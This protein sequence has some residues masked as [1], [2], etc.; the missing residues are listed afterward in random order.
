MPVYKHDADIGVDREVDQ[1][2]AALF[3]S[4]GWDQDST[5]AKKHYRRFYN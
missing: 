3:L 4:L 2:S 5:T 1:P